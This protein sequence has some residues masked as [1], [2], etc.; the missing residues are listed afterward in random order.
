MSHVAVHVRSDDRQ[1]HSSF[2]S[3]EDL[4]SN[5]VGTKEQRQAYLNAFQYL[6]KPSTFSNHL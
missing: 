6:C 5:T 2:G 4:E 3:V 1:H